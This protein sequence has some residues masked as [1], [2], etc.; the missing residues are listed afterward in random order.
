MFNLVDTALRKIDLHRNSLTNARS[1]IGFHEKLLAAQLDRLA[2]GSVDSRLV[3]E[4]EEKLSEA[5]ATAVESM[6]MERKARLELEAVR[7]TLLLA[8]DAEVDLFELRK[9]TEEFLRKNRD[10]KVDEAPSIPITHG[11]QAP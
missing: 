10:Q 1:V 5:R 3:L 2:V 7:G 9:R 4:T 11:T 6:V 8:R